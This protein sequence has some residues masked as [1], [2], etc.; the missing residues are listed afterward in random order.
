MDDPD[1]LRALLGFYVDLY[2]SREMGSEHA[3]D[4]FLANIP[5]NGS[6]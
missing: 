3:L 1:I 5:F 2:S 4:D 6:I